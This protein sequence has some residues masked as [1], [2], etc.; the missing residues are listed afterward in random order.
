MYLGDFKRMI[1]FQSKDNVIDW[2][3]DNCP[4]RS[5]VRALEKGKI[6]YLG[7]FSQIPPS[8][9]PGWILKVTSIYGG[10]WN[11]V[12]LVNDKDHRYE[13]RIIKTVPWK[14]WLGVAFWDK[15][16]FAHELLSGDHPKKYKELKDD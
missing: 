8:A 9:L 12:V 1:H 5:I 14:N 2:L 10:K 11:V 3:I 13:I 6:E 4:R 7:G 15:N 16:C